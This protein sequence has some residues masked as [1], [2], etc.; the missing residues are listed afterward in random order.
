[1]VFDSTCQIPPSSSD[2][3]LQ[4]PARLRPR[5]LPL[6]SVDVW[7]SRVPDSDIVYANLPDK[8]IWRQGPSG[9]HYRNPPFKEVIIRT[10]IYQTSTTA[11]SYPLHMSDFLLNLTTT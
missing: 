11:V 8:V 4:A 6:Q 9:T 3:I 1:M 2:R 10:L 5:S 7:C